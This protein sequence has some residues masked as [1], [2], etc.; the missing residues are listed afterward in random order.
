MTPPAA[1]AARAPSMSAEIRMRGAIVSFFHR[2]DATIPD[3]EQPP[4]LPS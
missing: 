4:R 2:Y 3:R 1:A